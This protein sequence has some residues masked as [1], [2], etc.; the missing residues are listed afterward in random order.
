MKFELARTK[1]KSRPV[2]RLHFL[3]YEVYSAFH[4]L[5]AS[6]KVDGLGTTGTESG[7]V[8]YFKLPSWSHL[9][10]FVAIMQDLDVRPY[11][12]PKE[13]AV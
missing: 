8:I 2:V 7:W 1:D 3:D 11:V 10:D 12:L 6:W 9:T 13:A 5:L 4:R